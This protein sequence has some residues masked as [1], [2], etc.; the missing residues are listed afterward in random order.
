[1]GCMA[2]QVNHELEY[3]NHNSSTDVPVAQGYIVD[4]G[5]P[6]LKP[7]DMNRDHK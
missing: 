3:R 2:A 6:L 4:E 1:M 7:I 5:A